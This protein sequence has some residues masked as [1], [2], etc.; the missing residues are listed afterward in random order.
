MLAPVHLD[1]ALTE[2]TIFGSVGTSAMYEACEGIITYVL[3]SLVCWRA[4]NPISAPPS[5]LHILL[6]KQPPLHCDLSPRSCTGT[7]SALQYTSGILLFHR[8]DTPTRLTCS[9]L[10]LLLLLLLL[11]FR[12]LSATSQLL[13]LPL[14]LLPT[15]LRLDLTGTS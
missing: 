8:N 2:L 7:P 11:D 14:L 4:K 3:D 6:Q 5:S 15:H 12:S 10:W 13:V 9:T 1:P